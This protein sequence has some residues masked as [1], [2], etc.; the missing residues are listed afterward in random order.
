VTLLVSEVV[1]NAI[2]HAGTE[3]EV[4][5]GLTP[6]AVRIEVT[7]KESVLPTP[8]DATDEETSGRGLALLEA[9]ASAWGVEAGPEGKV[10]WF[11]VPRLDERAAEG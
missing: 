8:R 2:V 3:V 5:V 9:L 1:T 10:V 7:D 11:E 6:D 4:S